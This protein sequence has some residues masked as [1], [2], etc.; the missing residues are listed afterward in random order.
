[1]LAASSQAFL[2]CPERV[3]CE[4]KSSDDHERQGQPLVRRKRCLVSLTDLA[5]LSDLPLGGF[6]FCNH[7]Q[8]V[9]T[10]AGTPFWGFPHFPRHHRDTVP[11]FSHGFRTRYLDTRNN[12]C[13]VGHAHPKVA[14]AVAR[15]AAELNTNTRRVAKMSEENR[16]TRPN[17]KS[18]S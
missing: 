14:A 5:F 9:V 2:S 10:V 13:H 7:Q 4:Y 3:I 1:M 8:L 16:K 12:V 18:P 6:S 17:P 15:Q 11:L